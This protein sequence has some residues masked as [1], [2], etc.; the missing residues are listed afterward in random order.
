MGHR[1][2]V[3]AGYRL[4]A[5]ALWTPEAL[6]LDAWYDAHD[7]GT[8]TDVSGGISVWTDKSGNGGTIVQTNAT[9]RPLTGSRNLNG[10]NVLDFDGT[11]HFMNFSPTLLDYIGQIWGVCGV[12]DHTTNNKFI[13]GSNNTQIGVENGQQNMRLWRGGNPY[14]GDNRGPSIT[15]GQSY[16]MGWIGD[17]DTKKF[18]LDGTLTTTTDTYDG[19]PVGFNV[20]KLGQGDFSP[21]WS[22]FIGEVILIAADTPRATGELIEGYLAWKWGL[23]ANLP[24]L[25]PYK[26]DPPFRT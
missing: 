12:D 15:A 23:V 5:D 7:S 14:S 17:T 8:I 11:N 9:N 4:S 24:A 25:H 22:G 2:T 6:T 1:L 16:I 13:G 21:V 19:S 20:N 26:D 10:L 3:P 18:S